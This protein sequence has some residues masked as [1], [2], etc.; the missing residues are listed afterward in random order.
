M[1]LGCSDGDT[2]GGAASQ[3]EGEDVALARRADAGDGSAL[4][5]RLS[6]ANR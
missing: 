6:L 4:C 2:G 3:T 5:G 1:G